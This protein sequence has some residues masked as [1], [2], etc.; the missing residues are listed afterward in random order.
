MI[1]FYKAFLNGFLY[2]GFIW[3]VVLGSQASARLK[4]GLEGFGAQGSGP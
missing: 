3:L 2:H 4:I 1:K